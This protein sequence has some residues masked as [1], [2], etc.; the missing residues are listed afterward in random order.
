VALSPK[1]AAYL[2]RKFYVYEL[3]DPDGE[4]FY[5]GKGKGRRMYHHARNARAGVIDNVD[6][7][8]R[9]VAI[10]E[11]GYE[12]RYRIVAQGLPE[13]QAYELEADRIRHHGI[14]NLTNAATGFTEAQKARAKAKHLLSRLMPFEWWCALAPRSERERELYWVVHDG[15]TRESQSA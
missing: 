12:V 2:P 4:V 5:V 1:R 9:I 14:A 8:E 3:V 11:R 10:H 13:K 7:H 6:K 15:L